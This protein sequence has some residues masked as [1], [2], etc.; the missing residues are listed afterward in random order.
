MGI[1]LSSGSAALVVFSKGFMPQ[2]RVKVT[3]AEALWDTVSQADYS[4]QGARADPGSR[5]GKL[6]PTG[7][8]E[9][10]TEGP[11]APQ[12][13]L[14]VSAGEKV[15]WMLFLTGAFFSTLLISPFLTK[16]FAPCI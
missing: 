3:G 6:L 11:P 2:K 7:C 16:T 12:T 5:G 15:V 8:S 9:A 1:F 4:C 13:F 14:F 10:T